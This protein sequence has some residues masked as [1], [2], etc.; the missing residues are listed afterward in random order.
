MG[1]FARSSDALVFQRFKLCDFAIANLD[2]IHLLTIDISRG[3]EFDD[4]AC[5]F[6]SNRHHANEFTCHG[7][8]LL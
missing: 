4:P 7:Y 3:F 6:C 5:R 8:L 1:E 2:R